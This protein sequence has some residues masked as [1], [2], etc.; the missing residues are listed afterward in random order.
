[1][2]LFWVL[3]IVNYFI[4]FAGRHRYLPAGIPT[5]LYDEALEVLLLMMA[6]IDSS[7][8]PKFGRAMN[9]MMLGIVIWCSFGLIEIF[10]DTCGLGYNVGAWFAGYRLLCFQLMWIILVFTVYINTPERLKKL[11]KLWAGLS[12]FSALWTYKQKNMGFTPAESAWLASNTTHILQGGSLIRYFSTFSDAANYGC[13]AAATATTFIV[14]S[15]TTRIRKERLFY[16]FTAFIVMWGMFQSGTRTAIF[17]LGFGLAVFIVLSKSVKIAVPSAIVFAL[18]AFMLIFTNIGN[19]NQQIRRMRS[20]FNKN[21]A[22][23][24]QRKINQAVMKKYMAD[25][26][27]GIGI[28]MGMDNVPSNNKFRK[29][30]TLPPDSEYIFI[31]IRT[32]AIGITVFLVSMAIMF[33]GA[34][35]IV[36]FKL[37]TRSLMGVGAGICGAFAAMQL[38]GYGNQVLY[39]YPN[40]LIFFGTLAIVY[41][42]PQMEPEWVAY[43][44]KLFAKQEEEKR[45]KLEKKRAS[46]V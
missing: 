18:F 41:V 3:F 39:Q 26:P 43:E 36:F 14:L 17:C 38:G 22:S 25:A 11:F 12:I 45:L 10:N 35:W 9:L 8:D 34:C 37:K 42:L 5:S 28:G 27:W 20:A 33:L 21:E 13:N 4:H 30:S 19:G 32:G 2:T 23:T 1:M 31:W 29:L 7:K 40:G 15:I 16:L 24:E 6:V 44:E 46:R